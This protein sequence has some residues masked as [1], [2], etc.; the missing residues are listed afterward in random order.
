MQIEDEKNG[1]E[2][3][4]LKI[5]F[6]NAKLPVNVY[7]KAT[8]SFICV[9]PS[10]CYPL[11]N[12]KKVPEG[13]TVR[14]RRICNTAEKYES[15]VDKHKNCLLAH[16]YKASFAD[17]QLKKIAQIS[18]DQAGESKPKTN[19]VSKIKFVTKYKA[20]LPKIDGIIKK[21]ISILH[22]NHAL[23]TLFTTDFFCTIYKRNKN[24][25]ELIAPSTYPKKINT[26]TSSI[27]KL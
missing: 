11:K 1:L 12:I 22:N 6:L 13:I 8:N 18:R 15:R 24:L 20:L 9:I 10:T 21:Y 26:G 3:L 17:E 5:K 4:D 19:Q 27:T 7:S 2:F 23:K 25:K 14:L 16:D